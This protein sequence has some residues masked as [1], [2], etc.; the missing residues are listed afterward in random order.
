[1]GEIFTV[2]IEAVSAL[3]TK[4]YTANMEVNG[5]VFTIDR[6]FSKQAYEVEKIEKVKFLFLINGYR[7]TTDKGTLDF[8][9]A[10][11]SKNKEKFR[12]YAESFR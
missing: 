4:K 8:V 1:M 3:G 5:K 12:E 6:I 7:A 11:L 10:L 2:A 9:L